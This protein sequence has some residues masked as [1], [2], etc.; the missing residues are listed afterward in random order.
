MSQIFLLLLFFKLTYASVLVKRSLT[1]FLDCEVPVLDGI[2]GAGVRCSLTSQPSADMVDVYFQVSSGIAK[3]SV[4]SLRFTKTDWNIR[5]EVRVYAPSC[6]DGDLQIQIQAKGDAN[7]GAQYQGLQ[8]I[9][10]TQ[11]CR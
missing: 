7:C 11:R 8:T 5:K 6:S 3:L 9:S 2:E 10:V 1:N 4:C